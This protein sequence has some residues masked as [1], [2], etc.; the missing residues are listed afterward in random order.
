MKRESGWYWVLSN[1]ENDWVIAYYDDYY[2][3]WSLTGNPKYFSDISFKEIDETP[4]TRKTNEP[5]TK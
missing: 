3:C 5:T 4:I 2:F 1:F